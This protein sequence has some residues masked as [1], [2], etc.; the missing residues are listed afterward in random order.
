MDYICILRHNFH[1]SC[2]KDFRKGRRKMS[3]RR[4]WKLPTSSK[5]ETQ[6]LTESCTPR[7]Y[8]GTK[9]CDSHFYPALMGRR[10]SRPLFAIFAIFRFIDLETNPISQT[11]FVLNAPADSRNREL[12][13]ITDISSRIQTYRSS[14]L[15][16]TQTQLGLRAHYNF[17]LRY[18]PHEIT[19]SIQMFKRFN[20]LKFEK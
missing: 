9:I 8:A 6:L 12:E 20:I 5:D 17:H 15:A 2:I 11:P 10:Q 16:I 13:N 14:T 4:H 18:H 7:I 3:G 19:V 1:Y